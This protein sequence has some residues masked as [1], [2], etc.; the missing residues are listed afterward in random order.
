MDL[1]E[2]NHSISSIC[3]YHFAIRFLP[4]IFLDDLGILALVLPMV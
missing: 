1:K 4:G 3:L 2:C